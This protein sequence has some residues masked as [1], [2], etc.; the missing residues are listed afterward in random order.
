MIPTESN[1]INRSADAMGPFGSRTPSWNPPSIAA[2][3]WRSRR[4]SALPHGDGADRISQAFR[5]VVCQ[6]GREQQE[7]IRNGEDEQAVRGSPISPATPAQLGRQHDED[8][9]ADDGGRTIDRPGEPENERE[10]GRR[11]QK[12]AVDQDLP[13]CRNAPADNGQH[14]HARVGIVVDARKRQRPKVR[15]RP[16]E[17]D[18]EQNEWLEPNGSSNHRPTDD[19]GKRAGGATNDNVPRRPPLEPNRI[20][21]DIE[22]DREGEQRGG[23]EVH[24]QRENDD[25]AERQGES[26]SKRLGA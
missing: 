12:R 1:R 3:N 16:Q 11:D 25:G 6:E 23:R 14:R 7:E 5:V 22:E 10:H 26:K 24:G 19:W 20:H 8:R 18:Q 17:N 4:M 13:R 2:L 15:R 21:N 9:S